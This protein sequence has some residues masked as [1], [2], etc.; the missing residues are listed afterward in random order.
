MDADFLQKETKAT[1]NLCY[2]RALLFKETVLAAKRR[3]GRK[4]VFHHVGFSAFSMSV[5]HCLAFDW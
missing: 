2:L 3:K 4:K 5:F 1:K